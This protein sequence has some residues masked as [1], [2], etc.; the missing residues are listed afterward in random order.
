MRSAKLLHNPGAGEG[1]LTEEEL[2]S[3]IKSAGYDCSYSSTKENGWEK[4]EPGENDFVVLA[5]G[6]GT[7]RKVAGHL[8]NKNLPIGLL[9]SGTA[10]N[11]ANTLG[12]SGEASDI[13]RSW[14]KD[15]IKKYD[16]GKIFGLG[17]TKF[18]LEGLGYGIFPRLMKEMKS[19]KDLDPNDRDAKIRTA[20]D[21][22]H[23]IILSYEARNCS[24]KVDDADFSGKFLLAEVMNI[25]SIGPNLNLAP[26]ADPGDGELEVVMITERQ[27]A[28]FADYVL[29]KMKGIEEPPFFNILKAKKLEIS[30]DGTHLHVDD[31]RITLKKPEKIKI[32]LQEGMME[33]LLPENNAEDPNKIN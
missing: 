4:L 28:D 20:W 3:L 10:N 13:I 23:D 11:I 29:K 15:R 25:K 27:R 22:L 16:V 21:I 5:G 31:E 26:F 8:L 30:W 18:F 32:V 6:D 33:F 1:A 9:P 17:K 24:I 12:I 14:S 2:V 7:I 19:Q